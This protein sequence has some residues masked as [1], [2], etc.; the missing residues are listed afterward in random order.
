MTCFGFRVVQKINSGNVSSL[1]RT[2]KT[3]FLASM[4]RYF[5]RGLNGNI[6]YKG[7]YVVWYVTVSG[8]FTS[9]CSESSLLQVMTNL[10]DMPC[11]NSL[12]NHVYL[13]LN[14]FIIHW[15]K[16]LTNEWMTKLLVWLWYYRQP[17]R[18]HSINTKVRKCELWDEPYL[19]RKRSGSRSCL[20]VADSHAVVGSSDSVPGR[21]CHQT[22]WPASSHPPSGTKT[23]QLGL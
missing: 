1:Q 10:T 14:S 6:V 15:N 5:W 8:L 21:W 17:S 23:E 2:A 16:V 20:A 22:P 9:D 3:N 18:C 11:K 13:S 4:V 7:K 12:V 19:A